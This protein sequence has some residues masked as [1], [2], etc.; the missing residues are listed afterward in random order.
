MHVYSASR[1]PVDIVVA[2]AVLGSEVNVCVGK[3]YGLQASA[4]YNAYNAGNRGMIIAA[5]PRQAD[6]IF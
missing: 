4:P 2:H 5:T 6:T 1:A 3:A